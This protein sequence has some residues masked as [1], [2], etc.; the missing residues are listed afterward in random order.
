M[1]FCQKKKRANKYIW[2]NLAVQYVLSAKN[3]GERGICF[4]AFQATGTRFRM[5]KNSLPLSKR[6]WKAYTACLFHTANCCIAH[7]STI[8]WKKISYQVLLFTYKK[9]FYVQIVKYRKSPL[10]CLWSSSISE[11]NSLVQIFSFLL[12][13]QSKPL[14]HASTLF[15]YSGRSI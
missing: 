5:I 8:Q 4:T 1:E 9:I 14:F 2:Q 10:K 13:V 12:P 11:S 15:S 7:L 6:L 3:S